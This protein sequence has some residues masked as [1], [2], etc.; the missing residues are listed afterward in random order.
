MIENQEVL[1]RETMRKVS[2]R[3]LPFLFGLYV[4]N[5]L[6]RSNVAL[7]A[8]QMNRDL[9]FSSSAFGFG[10]GIFFIG[11]SIFEVPSNVVLHRVGARKW[12]ARIMISW[13][14]L[15]SL[16]MFVRTPTQFYVVRFLL[17]AAEAGFFPGVVYYLTQW[18]PTSRRAR[19][20]S[21]FFIA[22]PVSGI[23]GGFFGGFLLTLDGHAGLAGWQWLFLMEGLPSVL[24]GITVLW[25]LT[26][27]PAD[28]RWLDDRQ[29]AWLSETMRQDHET[30]GHL[31]AMSLWY[32]LKQPI[33]WFLTLPYF[34]MLT[35]GYGY[36]FWMPLVV[37]DT[38]HTT[39][40]RTALITAAIAAVSMLTMLAAAWSSDRMHERFYHAAAS[41]V[42]IAIGFAG[43]ALLPQPILK[44]VFLG[45]V[46]IGCNMMLAPFWCLPAMVLSG[47]AAAVGIALIN[48][49]GNIG[50]FVGPYM[51]GF[52]KDATGSNTA[53]FLVL[54]SFGVGV[55]VFSVSLRFTALGKPRTPTLSGASDDTLLVT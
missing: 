20:T 30:A 22:I 17:G 52:L 3:L 34:L 4:L 2:V 21:R 46:L 42:F 54:A 31:Q 23:L 28:A 41:G 39:D 1:E 14:I 15:A 47:G 7:A 8:L 5:F 11:Y 53:V 50:G 33:I 38:L 10:A 32:A 27:K 51:I 12:I 49:V 16:M 25:Y 19:A 44:I 48:S 35:A 36:T 45:L 40:S 37:R 18:F 26:D 24:I 9:H 29:R 55:T 43:A 6:D 13:G